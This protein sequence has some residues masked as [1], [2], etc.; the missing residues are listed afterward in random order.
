MFVSLTLGMIE[1]LWE[2]ELLFF[3]GLL[4]SSNNNVLRKIKVMG[5]HVFYQKVSIGKILI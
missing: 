4:C 3:P 5:L 2:K 1:D